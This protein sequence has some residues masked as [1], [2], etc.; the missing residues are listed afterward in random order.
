MIEGRDTIAQAQAGTGKTGAFGIGLLQR[1]NPQYKGTQAIVVAPTRELVDQT[2]RVL[3][4]LGDYLGTTVLGTV[5]GRPLFDDCEAL[6]EGRH[7]VV[8]TPGR[9]CSLVRNKGL[10]L[11]AVRLVVLDEAD[12]LLDTDLRV[13]VYEV[14]Q[15]L[16]PD[17]QMCLFSATMPLACYE[18]AARFCHEPATMLVQRD[19]VTMTG[20]RHFHVTLPRDDDK[21]PTL[22]DLYEV[23]DINQAII[24]CNSVAGVER[25]VEQLTAEHF[26]VVP[27]H[28]DLPQETREATMRSFRTGAARVLVATDVLSRGID[29][30]AVSHVINWDLPAHKETYVHRVG[31]STRFNR[32]GVA[33]NLVLAR[34]ARILDAI[35][36]HYDTDIPELPHDLAHL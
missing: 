10:E 23:L 9:L 35:R 14:L 12:Q 13:Q 19:E 27:F 6:R 24:F 5:G 34:Q 33:I 22:C 21:F 4:C 26:T 17:V 16:R 28:S 20:V 8:A 32:T 15:K 30:P 11:K 3:T 1:V 25:L 29:V 2:A 18:M 36:Q 31:R 7:I